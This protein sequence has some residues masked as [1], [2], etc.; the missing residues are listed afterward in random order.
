MAEYLKRQNS[1]RIVEYLSLKVTGLV[2]S[3]H[4]YIDL[5]QDIIIDFDCFIQS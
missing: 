3:D 2:H 4:D 5:S 1:Q